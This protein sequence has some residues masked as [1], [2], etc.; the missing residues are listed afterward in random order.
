[1][2]LAPPPTPVLLHLTYLHHNFLNLWSTAVS[3]SPG[4]QLPRSHFSSSSII[5]WALVLTLP[6]CSMTVPWADGWGSSL[7]WALHSWPITL[8]HLLH[9]EL[10]GWQ[11]LKLWPLLGNG[12]SHMVMQC[13]F[14]ASDSSAEEL[15][16]WGSAWKLCPISSIPVLAPSSKSIFIFSSLNLLLF[17]FFLLILTFHLC[18]FL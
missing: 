4:I 7:A 9:E 11:N 8:H 3:F 10:T 14:Q 6:T 16:A 12:L 2:T 1:M 18:L 15:W 17:C 5:L 13:S